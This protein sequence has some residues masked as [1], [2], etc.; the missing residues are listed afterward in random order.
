MPREEF[1]MADV[2]KE[3]SAE[4]I[5]GIARASNAAEDDAVAGDYDSEG[6]LASDSADQRAAYNASFKK[7]SK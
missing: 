6:K 4:E 1:T 2:K 7:A 3:R 5:A